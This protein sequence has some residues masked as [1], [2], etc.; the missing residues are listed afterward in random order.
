M[1]TI[2]ENIENIDTKFHNDQRKT[3]GDMYI[4]FQGGLTFVEL[5]MLECLQSAWKSILDKTCQS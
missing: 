1:L 3:I 2:T 4:F 5:F